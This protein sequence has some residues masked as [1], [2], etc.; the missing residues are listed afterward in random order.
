MFSSGTMWCHMCSD[1]DWG[2]PRWPT[3]SVPGQ[4]VPVEHKWSI[5]PTERHDSRSS[6]TDL[7]FNLW[8]CVQL[9]HFLFIISLSE[10]ELMWEC[11]T[12]T[13]LQFSIFSL[14]TGW[15]TE[16]LITMIIIPML[17]I[18]LTDR[19]GGVMDDRYRR[20]LDCILNF[21]VSLFNFRTFDLNQDFI[22]NVGGG[23]GW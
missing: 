18:W 3:N 8:L 20:I 14:R 16:T 7:L 5:N 22:Q 1:L 19:R 13:L 17:I 4:A 9:F 21:I 2:S 6:S 11:Y 12:V 10:T 23:G 15:R